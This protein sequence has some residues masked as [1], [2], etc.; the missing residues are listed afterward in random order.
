MRSLIYSMMTS[1]DGFIESDDRSLNWSDPDEEL[2]TFANEQA[3]DVGAYLYGRR[4]YEV[5]AAYWPTADQDPEAPRHEV[6]FA[7]LWRDIPKIVFS[8]TL[9]EV[10]WNSVLARGDVRTEV[11][12]LKHETGKDLVVGGAT[13]ASTLVSLDLVDEYRLIVHPVI[14]G[15]GKPYFPPLDRRVAL[16]LVETRTFKSGVVY[17]RYRRSGQE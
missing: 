17:L 4:L 11:L 12:Q 9:D 15:S 10:A 1:L 7:R 6:E 14:L 3:R 5:M 8:L 13:L 2:H 16:D